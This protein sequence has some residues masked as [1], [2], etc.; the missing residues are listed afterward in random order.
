M[1]V[2]CEKCQTEYEFDD[3]LVTDRGVPVKCTQCG[4]MFTV[5]PPGRTGTGGPRPQPPPPPG[6][7]ARTGR[8]SFT[9]PP[10]GIA[11]SP[12]SPALATSAPPWTLR[13]ATSRRAYTFQDLAQLR[14]WIQEGRV[15]PNDEVARPGEPWR[16]VSSVPELASAFPQAATSRDTF[17]LGPAPATQ[18]DGFTFGTSPPPVV[19]GALPSGPYTLGARPGP[20]GTTPPYAGRNSLPPG[21]AVQPGP[22]RAQSQ[23]PSFNRVP[24]V[25][26][27]PDPRVMTPMPGDPR[28]VTPMPGEYR[29]ESEDIA[30]YLDVIGISRRR[31][32]LRFAGLLFLLL[33]LAMAVGYLLARDH[34]RELRSLAVS[35]GIMDSQ[36]TP[37]PGLVVVPLPEPPP[38]PQAQSHTP[39]NGGAQVPG[40]NAQPRA[41]DERPGTGAMAKGAREA[42]QSPGAQASVTVSGAKTSPEVATTPSRSEAA[43]SGAGAGR[44]KE[45]AQAGETKAGATPPGEARTKG[46]PHKPTFD[47]LIRVA[48]G[49]LIHGRPR[50]AMEL[51]EQA[52]ALK[53]N[54]SEALTGLGWCHINLGRPHIAILKFQKALQVNPSYGDALIGLGKAYRIMG[55]L[56]LARD[57]YRRYLRDHPHGSKATIAKAALDQLDAG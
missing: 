44:A 9:G 49:H 40:G 43:K 57:A 4:H 26:P 1:E 3:S 18:T 21:P 33:V 47:G 35:W 24:S 20:H 7:P 23:G 29:T 11:R 15:M 2:R 8:G 39:G 5:Y 55:K 6:S 14:Q 31:R 12:S 52:L 19:E 38:K 46:K 36:P 53:P 16:K 10:P 41:V 56:D 25:V 48:K 28:Y 42:E 54:R 37:E 51:Y 22:W 45:A 34:M 50:K 13:Q 27:G 30:D 17:A 32:W